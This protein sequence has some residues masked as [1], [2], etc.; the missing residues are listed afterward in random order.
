M[1]R[2][3][4]ALLAL[5]LAGCCALTFTTT[6]AHAQEVAA[7][8]HEATD[9][10]IKLQNPVAALISVPLQNNFEFNGGPNHDPWSR[11]R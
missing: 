5:A 10:A 4:Q 11:F 6:T 8:A 9:L 2:T 1:K 3:T 7:V